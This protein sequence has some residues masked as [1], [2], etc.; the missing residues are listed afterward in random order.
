MENKYYTPSIE[1]FHV[2]F[3][4]EMKATFGDG[5]VKTKEQYDNAEWIKQEY[6]LRSFPYV[7]RTMTGKNSE[8]LPSAIRVKYL[9]KADIEELGFKHIGGKLLSDVLQEFKWFNG[10]YW[11]YLTYTKFT[12]RCV[13][14]IKT[15]VEDESVK[16]LVV[17]SIGIKN[18]SELKRLLK[19]LGI[20]QS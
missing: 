16:T 6:T 7:D 15:S 14:T 11:V 13:L 18:K 10:R 17:H 20:C 8:S 4:Y 12:N 1:E 5:T 9:D 3:E 2:G 19:Q